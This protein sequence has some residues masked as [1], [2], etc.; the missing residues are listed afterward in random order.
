M[1]Q[2][3]GDDLISLLPFPPGLMVSPDGLHIGE[4]SLGPAGRLEADLG[5]TGDGFQIFRFP[6]HDLQDPLDGTLILAGMELLQLLRAHQLLIYLGAV[7][8]GTGAKA[9]IDIDIRPDG[10]LGQPHIVAQHLH[11]GHLRKFGSFLPL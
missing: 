7:L 10:L 9:D 5:H 3:G 8:H 4:N 1:G 11:L 2:D 6:V